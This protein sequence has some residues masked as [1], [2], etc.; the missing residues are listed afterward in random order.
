MYR[1]LLLLIAIM[2]A[3]S[4]PALAQDTTALVSQTNDVP[5]SYTLDGFGF[6]YQGWNNCGPATLTNA[7]TFFGYGDDQQRAANW[8]KPNRED[9]N[10]SPDE[11][12]SFV[13][14]Q[15]PEIPV[16]AL[17]R[18]GGDLDLLK[19][20][21]ASEFPVIIE[22]GYDPPGENL[23]WMGH[24]LLI[25]GYDDAAQEFITQDSYKGPNLRY[26]YDHIEEYWRH[27]N[28]RYIVVYE[29]GREPELLELLGDDADPQQNAF[30]ALEKARQ[31]ATINP[32]DPFSWFNIGS[33][34]VALAPTYQQQAYEYA[35]VA[36]DEARKYD[37][38]WRMIWYQFEPLE[39]YN[40]VGRYEDTLS[41]TNSNLN[42]GGGHWVEETFYYAGVAREQMGETQRALDNYRQAVFLNSNYTEAREAV[43]RLAG[44]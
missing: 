13:N 34:Y 24:Y 29:S 4:V 25:S 9:K 43:D 23:G 20:L 21:I 26:S 5:S 31:D 18:I 19:L 41:L 6:E 7:L 3:A 40:A 38:P 44:T 17:T 36:F 42:D 15:I 28:W 22:E 37:L 11:M 30:N 1:K 32:Q 12:V 35:V 33:S 39:A 27:F 14:S 2:M 10:V 16:Y 8:L